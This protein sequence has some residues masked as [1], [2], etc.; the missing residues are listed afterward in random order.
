MSSGR[1]ADRFIFYQ[2]DAKVD[3]QRKRLIPSCR[4]FFGWLLSITA[5]GWPQ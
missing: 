3:V 5:S 2:V 4:V 1:K